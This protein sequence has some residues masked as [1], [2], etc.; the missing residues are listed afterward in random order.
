MSDQY[1]ETLYVSNDRSDDDEDD[2][3][4]FFEVGRK[5]EEV[6]DLST[7]GTNIGIYKLIRVA[8]GKTK[9]YL[10]ME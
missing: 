9:A 4:D 8:K 5:L 2:E 7:E 1:P 3:S 10:S 6:V